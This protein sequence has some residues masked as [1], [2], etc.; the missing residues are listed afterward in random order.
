MKEKIN[1]K[2]KK[3]L[4]EGKLVIIRFNEDMKIKDHSNKVQEVIVR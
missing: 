4:Q 2:I 3:A 1:E